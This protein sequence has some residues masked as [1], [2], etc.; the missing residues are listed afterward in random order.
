MTSRSDVSTSNV[1]SWL[2]DFAAP[3]S[4]HRVGS[5]PRARSARA[6]PVRAEAP[7]GQSSG[8]RAPGRRSSA[9]PSPRSAA[10]SSRPRPTGA[11]IGSGA[12]NAASSPAARRRARR[13]CAGP[14]RP[15]PRA[16]VAATPTEA[17]SPSSART[18]S[19]IDARDRRAV[20]E[21]RSATGDVEERLVDR[22]RLDERREPPEDRHHLP[23]DGA[24]TCGRRPA[25][26]PRRGQSARRRP[27][28]H[29]GVDPERA[30]LVRG[31]ADTTPRS[32]GPPPPTTTGLPR[33]SGRS[34][35]STAAKNASRSTW[36]IV[37]GSWA[38]ASH[39]VDCHVVDCH[40]ARA[41]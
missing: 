20:A 4:L 18:A 10:A 19:L 32:P 34:R 9:P 8:Q 41:T 33:S 40:P 37:R 26:R 25:G 36:R 14:R 24:G 17:V 2:T 23:A 35:C 12:R 1:C 30:R 7:H 22:D 16:C 11:R 39:V 3:P 13:A 15:S 28:R 5:I 29:R 21:E 31:R 6:G 38:V 27:E